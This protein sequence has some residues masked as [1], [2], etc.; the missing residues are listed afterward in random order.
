MS[1]QVLELKQLYEQDYYLWLEKT[2]E[3]LKAGKL[4]QLDR[5]NLIEEISSG[6]E[7]FA[8][9]NGYRDDVSIT[10]IYPDRVFRQ[11][12]DLIINPSMSAASL[13]AANGF[14]WR[15]KLAGGQLENC[16]IP[17]LCNHFLQ[18]VG[19]DQQRCQ[20]IFTVLAEMISNALDH[21]VL[22]LPSLIKES[23][24]GF[25]QYYCE[26]EGRLK[27]LTEKD[28]IILSVRWCPD[29]SGGI[30]VLEVEDSGRGYTPIVKDN[31]NA[32]Q[33]SGRGFELIKKL[34]ETVEIIAPGNKIRATLK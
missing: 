16:E 32:P 27:L 21:G 3:L 26:R 24:D 11:L 2:I 5:E 19:F 30:L 23:S 28:F 25:I 17:P 20:K 15:V 33:Y 6:L 14:E 12:T 29:D 1:T 8:G 7:K 18:Q 22:E 4:N 9:T 31:K 10:I 13:T 34:S